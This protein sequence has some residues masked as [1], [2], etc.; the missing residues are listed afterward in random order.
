MSHPNTDRDEDNPD[1]QLR[2]IRERQVR[3]MRPDR[4]D[5]PQRNADSLARA[6]SR[7]LRQAQTDRGYLLSLYDSQ[8]SDYAL[9]ENYV[10]EVKRELGLPPNAHLSISLDRYKDRTATRMRS[11]CIETVKE[12]WPRI[13]GE[14]DEG[15]RELLFGALVVKLENLT[16]NG[17]EK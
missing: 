15:M 12:Y 13:V 5:V 8:T 16:L 14:D 10:A 6:L 17:Q 4:D 9:V 7:E 11:H 3:C 2:Q 1:E